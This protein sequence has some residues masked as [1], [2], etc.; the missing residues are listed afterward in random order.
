MSK[1]VLELS[2][3]V[4]SGNWWIVYEFAKPSLPS[5]WER[6]RVIYDGL[7]KDCHHENI[8]ADACLV[9]MAHRA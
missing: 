2:I 6:N 4:F 7:R 5:F 8:Q 9:V 1:I 3:S